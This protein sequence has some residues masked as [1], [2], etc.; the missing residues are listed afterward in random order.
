MKKIALFLV[1]ALLT[2]LFAGCAGTP[3]VYYTN[4]TC[5][6]AEAG[7]S[8]APEATV[9][10]TE[11][12]KIE[13]PVAEGELK[14]G[15]AIVCGLGKSTNATAEAAGAADYD[16]TLVAVLVDG[17]GVIQDCIIDSIGA[18][19]NFDTTGAITGL[20]ETIETKN[21]KGDAYNMV[22]YGG[23][24]AEWYVQ[25]AAVADYAVG[26]TADELKNGAVNESGYAKD[27][28]LA[29]S[30]TIYIGGYVD[31]IVKAVGNAEVK[32]AQAGDKLVLAT[33]PK[34]TSS[35]PADAEKAGNAQLDVDVVAM[36][37]NGETI[38]SCVID[39][40]QA[41]VAF[42]NTGVITTD[43]TAPV[44]TKNELGA[45]YNMVT[46]GGAIA[47]W[48]QQA[49]SF[50]QYVTGKTVAEVG[51]IAVDEG[52]K[53]TDADLTASVTISIGGFQ[54]LIAKAAK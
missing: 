24:I 50:C 21:E 39:S 8:A 15:L 38:T 26:K 35:T 49:A 44:L 4:C 53:P 36:T 43:L 28:D 14:T 37:L 6:V 41:K 29:S 51:G 20:P 16:V 34:A 46:Y 12:E 7:E 48:D 11:A 23:A 5:P 25:A 27:A 1:L 54:A 31:A 9:K 30:A 13:A 19:V 18:A 47:E 42:D 2:G 3:V 22:A 52:T 45:D 32:G 40:L 17:N 10:P 33:I